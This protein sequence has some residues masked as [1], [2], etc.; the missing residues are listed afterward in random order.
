MTLII[1]TTADSDVGGLLADLMREHPAR[2]I[3]VRASNADQ[4][5]TGSA[6]AECW[7][8]F[9]RKEQICCERIEIAGG[10]S[11]MEEA[12]LLVRALLA[13]DLPVVLYCRDASMLNEPLFTRLVP[14]AGKVIV[15]STDAPNFA[16][17]ANIIRRLGAGDRR[18][19]DL[20]WTHI[21][22]WREMI[23]QVFDD[24]GLA[25]HVGDIGRVTIEWEG[26][27]EPPSAY[28]LIAWLEHSLGR[29]LTRELRHVG[30]CT[31][32][33]V[34]AV[35][36]QGGDIDVC[37]NVEQS[38]ATEVTTG[39]RQRRTVLPLLGE[40]ELLAEELNVLGADSVYQG[41][42]QRLPGLLGGAAV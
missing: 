21:T 7:L 39:D 5:L 6:H 13:P 40:H 16:A 4:P 31:R 37:I 29:S 25:S 8:P 2:A 14:L 28:Y 33:R 20:A 10:P 34:R 17:Q 38:R 35:R 19:A 15:D 30:H 24:P 11:T 41:V 27:S 9:G 1:V 36:L 42:L 18:V 12:A 26:A 23:A 3:V 32:R 22:R